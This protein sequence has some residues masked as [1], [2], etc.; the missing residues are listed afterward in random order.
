MDVVT[1]VNFVLASVILILGVALFIKKKIAFAL[2]IGVAFGLFA[3]SWLLTLVNLAATLAIPL[4]IDRTLAYL[5]VIFAL[6]T[7]WK[8]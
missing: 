6:I 1:V 8:K 4:I 2:Y 5:I 3:I 7:L